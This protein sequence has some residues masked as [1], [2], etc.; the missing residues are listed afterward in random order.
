MWAGSAWI[1]APGNSF[2]AGDPQRVIGVGQMPL[3]GLDR[4]EQAV[5]DLAIGR[6]WRDWFD[7]PLPTRGE[8]VDTDTEPGG[9]NW[10]SGLG[11]ALVR[12]A[13]AAITVETIAQAE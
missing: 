11:R 8:Q 2:R 10:G 12:G 3:D 13:R 4:D 9:R 6:A 1:G 7:Y 5:G